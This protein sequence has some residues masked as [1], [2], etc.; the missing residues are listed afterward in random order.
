MRVYLVMEIW[1]SYEGNDAHIRGAGLTLDAAKGI[2]E[3]LSA[4]SGIHAE[5]VKKRIDASR[6]NDLLEHVTEYRNQRIWERMEEAK[7]KHHVNMANIAHQVTLAEQVPLWWPFLYSP[8]RGKAER[9]PD[10]AA[11][12]ERVEAD[13]QDEYVR[14]GAECDRLRAEVPYVPVPDE[15]GFEWAEDKGDGYWGDGVARS[16]RLAST[17]YY[18]YEVEV[19]T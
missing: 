1:E 16:W 8:T 3:K 6:E 19:A 18:V 12:R 9:L 5:R 15:L 14:Y 4:T 10:L 7:R 17:D 2:A 13:L 11:V